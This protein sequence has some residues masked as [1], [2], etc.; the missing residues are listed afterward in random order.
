[1][2]CPINLP[3]GL[4][5]LCPYSKE[6]LCDYPY[7]VDMTLSEIRELTKL[8]EDKEGCTSDMSDGE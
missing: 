8:L 7:S 2:S 5:Q 4:C 3:S 6:G 1:M